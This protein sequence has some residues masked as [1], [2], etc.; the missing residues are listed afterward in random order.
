[1]TRGELPDMPRLWIDS[2]VMVQLPAPTLRGENPA[3]INSLKMVFESML[4]P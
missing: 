3:Q 1:M 4:V 2:L